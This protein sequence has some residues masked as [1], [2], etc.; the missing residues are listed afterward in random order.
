MGMVRSQ[1]DF[2]ADDESRAPAL[3]CAAWGTIQSPPRNPRENERHDN[4]RLR[5]SRCRTGHDW[6]LL[7]V[8][9]KPLRA[10]RSSTNRSAQRCRCAPLASVPHRGLHTRAAE[11]LPRIPLIVSSTTQSQIVGRALAAQCP[12]LDVVELQA[13]TRPAPSPIWRDIAALLA[14]TQ[15]H[16]AR[17]RRRDRTPPLRLRVGVSLWPKIRLGW[18]RHS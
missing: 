15:H 13:P 3:M 8:A 18:G 17:N 5:S 2:E 9:L 16:L 10:V 1:P 11:A 12:G 6:P 4:E 14:V 7:F